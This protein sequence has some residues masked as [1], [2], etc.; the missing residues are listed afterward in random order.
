MDRITGLPMLIV[1]V[2]ISGIVNMIIS[3]PI[4]T[5]GQFYQIIGFG[6]GILLMIYVFFKLFL[7]INKV[8][9]LAKRPRLLKLANEFKSSIMIHK[10]HKKTLMACLILSAAF[11]II[12][13]ISVY[14]FAFSAN[15]NISFVN[16][17]FIVPLVLFVV[18]I[19]I[20]ING[21]G[22]QEGAF[23]FYFEKIGV[24]S[25]EAL[26]IAILPR[27]GALI[28]SLIGALLYMYESINKGIVSRP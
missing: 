27:I 18:M 20:S 6:F 28:F 22:I 8:A 4:I 16:L 1:I 25:S 3:K 7:G 12:N 11:Y 10:N 17:A 13:T 14:F 2:L 19:P 24:D 26:L 15:V 23:F 5:W 9:I 21:I